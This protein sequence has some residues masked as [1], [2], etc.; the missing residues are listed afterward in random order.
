MIIV[1]FQSV[2]NSEMYQKK[3]FILKKL[4]LISLHQNDPK[5]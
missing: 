4:S 2:L 1:V 3:S 5:K